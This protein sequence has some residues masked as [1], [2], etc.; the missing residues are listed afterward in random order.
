MQL[1]LKQLAAKAA[2]LFRHKKRVETA[3]PTYKT[4]PHPWPLFKGQMIAQK[5]YLAN[6]IKI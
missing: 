3:N 4:V 2:C 6:S 5:R 1:T